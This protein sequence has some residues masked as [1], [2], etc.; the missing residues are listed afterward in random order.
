[1]T[2]LTS[3]IAALLSGL[4]GLFLA[5]LI[6][7][8]CTSWYSISSREGQSGYYVI[9]MALGGGIVSFVLG[10]IT[11]RIVAAKFGA[12]FGKELGA[13]LAVI[14]ILAGL[15]ALLARTFADVPPEI[16]GRDLVL[17]VEFRF[18]NT[19]Q[20]QKTPT[21][22]GEWE[23]LLD[24]LSGH[25]RRTY[26]RGKVLSEAA[27]MEG[28][29]WI[30]P[31][32]VS[33]FTERGSRS[34]SIA[35][36]DAK[37]SFGFLLPIPSRPGKALLEWSVWLPRQQADGKPWPADKM[38]CRFR[39]Q[40]TVP[41]PPP[42]TEAELKAE[43]HA[44][45]VEE[46]EAIPADAPIETWFR[47]TAYQQPLTERALQVITSRSNYVAELS[48]LAIDA[49]AEK[50]HAAM[51]CI[52]QL[53]APSKELIPGIA[54]AGRLIATNIA[55][56][57]QTPK[58]QDPDF[59]TAVDPA[60][61][62]YGWIPAAKNLREKCGADLTPELK[63]ILELSRVRPES[64]CMRQDICRVASYYLH[65]WAGIAPLPTDPPPK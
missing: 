31:A 46:F 26:E 15:W 61:R 62:F 12:G 4:A 53:P 19:F 25:T 23:F 57:N 52:S 28:G 20:G 36:K 39:L 47:Y 30:V 51:I 65:Q 41:P 38:S 8:A 14:L 3:I 37:E 6:A 56:F 16:E 50:A 60:S 44:E 58:E 29:Q 17:E 42:K 63:A 43:K 13:A 55:K 35:P 22:E 9:F 18:P 10:L 11:V 5:G 24:S 49:D 64:H 1:M 54:A 7:N 27:R 48:A 2:W 33:L 32:T 21:T 40:K 34:V 45:E 59:A